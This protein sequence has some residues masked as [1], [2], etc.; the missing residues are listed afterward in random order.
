MST[1]KFVDDD[2]D[3]DLCG[4]PAR[5]LLACPSLWETRLQPF[6]VH[7]R[8]SRGYAKQTD[9]PD[10]DDQ[11]SSAYEPRL[12]GVATPRDNTATVVTDQVNGLSGVVVLGMGRGGTSAATQMFVR[13]GFY[14]GRDEDLMPAT[15]ANPAGHWEN[16]AIWRVN[17]EVLERLGGSWFDPPPTAAQTAARRWV[18]PLLDAEVQ[19]LTEQAHGAPIVVKDPRIGVMMPLWEPVLNELLHPVLVVRDPLEIALSL[20]E[21][22]GT[23][24]P[25]GLGMWELHMSSLLAHLQHKLVTIVP[26]A[27]L[28]SNVDLAPSIVEACIRRLIP[29]RTNGLRPDNAIAALD[30]K[31]HRNHTEDHD[32][33][34][35]LTGRQLE[36]W[37]WLSSLS[38]GNQTLDSSAVVQESADNGRFAIR[39]E[40][41]RV[42]MQASHSR[43]AH[44]VAHE[45]A[46]A[47]MLNAK[48]DDQQKTIHELD[49]ALRVERK[50]NGGLTEALRTSRQRSTALLAELQAER[51]R[52]N[53]AIE[54]VAHAEHWLNVV[55]SSASWRITRPMR[56]AKQQ[57]I[58]LLKC[59]ASA[60]MLRRVLAYARIRASRR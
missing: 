2:G 27:G 39:A 47:E 8:R 59:K 15:D 35:N 46:Q 19:R 40:S 24:I 12:P 3:P 54:S 41:Q 10:K 4:R 25:F 32:H 43:L 50:H 52:A 17:E 33:Q 21:R 45:Q 30:R 49:I 11:S 20:L 56:A 44:R 58:R 48:I 1:S 13:A 28:M 53:V 36:L 16:L 9:M 14:A 5:K 22:D 18:I 42:A 31:L 60:S 51:D 29:Q 55:L 38:A 37:L 7:R 6:E 23:P 26:Y 34:A 57:A